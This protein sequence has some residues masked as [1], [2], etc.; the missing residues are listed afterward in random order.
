M[1]HTLLVLLLQPLQPRVWQT[2]HKLLRR[3]SG[4]AQAQAEASL[5]QSPMWPATPLVFCQQAGGGAGAGGGEMTPEAA[6]ERAAAAQAAEERRG[7]MLS[8]V[9]RPPGRSLLR[10]VQ[11]GATTTPTDMECPGPTGGECSERRRRGR[12][13]RR[14]LPAAWRA[15]GRCRLRAGAARPHA[16]AARCGGAPRA[17][18]ALRRA[19]RRCCCSSATLYP[20]LV[21]C[22]LSRARQVLLPAARERLARIALVKPDKARGVEDLVLQAAQRGQIV[23]RA[24]PTQCTTLRMLSCRWWSPR[25]V[26]TVHGYRTWFASY[27][28]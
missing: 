5:P 13:R 22:M 27:V 11:S 23:E 14:A 17:D 19:R 3:S 26:Q 20:T 1:Q 15:R 8:Q 2:A 25:A 6:E 28:H 9:P 7:A 18:Q 16:R 12:A 4:R 24:R 10:C 21:T